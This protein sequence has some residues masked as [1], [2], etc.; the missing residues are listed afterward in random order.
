MRFLKGKKILAKVYVHKKD[1]F[2]PFVKLYTSRVMQKFRNFFTL[3]KF[4]WVKVSSSKVRK[5]IHLGKLN[6]C[7]KTCIFSP[8]S[9][10]GNVYINHSNKI[11]LLRGGGWIIAVLFSDM[12]KMKNKFN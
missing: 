5:P 2:D 9:W 11:N 7:K 4:M 10:Y 12:P 3:W 6:N 1:Y 8:Q